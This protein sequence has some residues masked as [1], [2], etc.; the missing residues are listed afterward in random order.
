ML[1]A[2]PELTRGGAVSTLAL[3]PLENVFDFALD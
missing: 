2:Y 1:A 3:S